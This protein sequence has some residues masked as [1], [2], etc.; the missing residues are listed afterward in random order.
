MIKYKKDVDNIVTL[1]M[2]MQGGNANILNHEIVKAFI[3]VIAHLKK[4][5]ARGAIKGV[6]ITSAKKTFLTGGGLDYLYKSTDPEAIFAYSQTME[7]FYRDLELPDIAVVAA[8]NGTALGNG[9]ELTLACHHRIVIDKPK[10]Y[11]GSPEVTLGLMPGGGGVIRMLWTLGL[12][13]SF[14]ILTEGKRYSPKEALDVGIIDELAKDKKDLMEKAK[15]WLLSNDKPSRPWDVKGS[16]IPGGTAHDLK[17]GKIIQKYTASLTGVDFSAPKAILST[18]VEGSKVNFDTATRIQSRYFTNLVVSK[19]AKNMMKCFWYDF[20]DIKDGLSRPKG[21]GRFRPKKVG[22]IGAGL[23]GSGIAY[24]CLM[25]DMEV[26]IKDISKA[27]AKRGKDMVAAKLKVLV[28]K[29]HISKSENDI[30]LDRIKTTEK[31]SDFVDCDLVIEAV[32]ENEAVKTKVVKEAEPDMDKYSFYATNTVSIQIS[33]LAKA[34]IRPS[35]FIG[36]HFFHPADKVP[37]VEIVKGEETSDE[38]VARAYDFVAAIRKIPIMVKDNWGFYAARVQNTYILE[39]VTMLQEGYDAA[40]IENL[41]RQCGMKIGPLKM[42][43]ELSLD[44]V[45][46]YENQASSHYGEKYLQH[47]AV[48]VLQIMMNEHDRS[49]QRQKNGFYTYGENGE[50]EI[51]AEIGEVFPKLD[52]QSD[53]K[54]IVDRLLFVQVL[55]AIWCLQEGVIKNIPEANLGSIHG[56]GF[57]ASKGGALQFVN[58]YGVQDFVK[59]C[60]LLKEEHGPR[61]TV[62]K[63]LLERARAYDLI[64]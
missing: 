51:W 52:D 28:N 26:V 25:N 32:F 34:S 27:V 40:L 58:D 24:S 56:W 14:P 37:V 47:P 60:N 39:G 46:K 20:N 53:I 36:L 29:G 45:L 63:L 4:E 16:K 38:T 33:K 64:E 11:L 54:T 50:E 12:E 61:F 21:F 17:V 6:I 18:L 55:E 7:Q 59:R 13:K 31:S 44:L 35:Q 48:T 49:A 15:K 23:M 3:P 9:F 22:V 1:T 41:G 57:P 30:Y 8:I 2:D 42:A 10:V 62:P 5:K 43:D 19:E